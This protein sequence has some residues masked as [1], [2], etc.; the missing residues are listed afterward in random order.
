MSVLLWIK[1]S[2]L[3]IETNPTS[4]IRIGG[5]GRYDEH[6]IFRFADVRKLP[7]R[8]MLVSVNTDDKGIFST[9]LH[10]ELSLLAYALSKQQVK[11]ARHRW[12]NGEVYNYVGRL[13]GA[14]QTNRFRL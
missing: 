2:G 11:G 10:R 8:N 4:N 6:P 5:L 7:C 1:R 9:S 14:G 3:C 12:T 13:A